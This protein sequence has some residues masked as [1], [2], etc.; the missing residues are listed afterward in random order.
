MDICS[1]RALTVEKEFISRVVIPGSIDL[2]KPRLK[3]HDQ[4]LEHHPDQA[5]SP[6]FSRRRKS[7]KVAPDDLPSRT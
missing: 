3:T 5:C 7:S 2:L 4:S 6:S 1:P